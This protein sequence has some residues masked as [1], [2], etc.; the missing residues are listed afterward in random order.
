ME[1][2]AGVYFPMGPKKI[3]IKLTELRLCRSGLI[4][5]VKSKYQT[6]FNFH[7]IKAPSFSSFFLVQSSSTSCTKKEEKLFFYI[8]FLPFLSK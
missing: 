4:P 3:V 7:L 5:P 2:L 6:S 1:I 8:F